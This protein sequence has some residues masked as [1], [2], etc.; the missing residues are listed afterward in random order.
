MAFIQ[1]ILSYSN[2]F[3]VSR[4]TPGHSKI[5]SHKVIFM[6]PMFFFNRLF[7][8]IS[9]FRFRSTLLIV[10]FQNIALHSLTQR[11]VMCHSKVGELVS[12]PG[13]LS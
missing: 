7:F 5:K 11:L 2:E 6:L 3:Q 13:G 12:S 4:K 9:W 10:L 8:P 1:E